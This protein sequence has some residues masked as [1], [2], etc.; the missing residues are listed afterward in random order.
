MRE[1]P[2]SLVRARLRTTSEEEFARR[3]SHRDSARTR[4]AD[5]LEENIAPDAGRPLDPV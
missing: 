3:L 4:S 5:Q 2:R 1:T